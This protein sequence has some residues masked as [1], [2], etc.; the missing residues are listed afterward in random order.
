[1][2]PA[3]QQQ[4]QQQQQQKHRALEAKKRRKAA[5]SCILQRR[6]DLLYAAFFIIHIPIM[7]CK[8]YSYIHLSL[9]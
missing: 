1:M 7:L 2:A 8:F 9:G 4:Q 6:F 5:Y 3:K